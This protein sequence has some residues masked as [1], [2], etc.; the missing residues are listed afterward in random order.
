MEFLPLIDALTWTAIIKSLTIVIAMILIL[1]LSKRLLDEKTRSSIREILVGLMIHNEYEITGKNK[2]S[3]RM[4]NTIN[5]CEKLIS[6]NDMKL[7]GGKKQLAK[8]AQS[9][10]ASAVIPI[11]RRIGH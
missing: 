7:I 10:F 2:G 3:E 6:E 4:Y 11:I 9:L 5:T 8:I 1:W